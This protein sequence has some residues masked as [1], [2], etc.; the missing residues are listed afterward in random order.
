MRY[1]QDRDIL[2]FTTN[3]GGGE[4]L[5]AAKCLNPRLL[6]RANNWVNFAE[7]AQNLESITSSSNIQG[8]A[9]DS[10]GAFYIAYRFLNGANY[11]IRIV[12]HS[13]KAGTAWSSAVTVNSTASAGIKESAII[14]MDENEYLHIIWTQRDT[15]VLWYARS[16]NPRSIDSWTTQIQI[17]SA[18][19]SDYGLFPRKGRILVAYRDSVSGD[20]KFNYST[21]RGASWAY[22]TAGSAALVTVDTNHIGTVRASAL[23]EVF[24][25]YNDTGED[26]RLTTFQSTNVRRLNELLQAQTGAIA[27]FSTNV[28]ETDQSYESAPWC[29]RNV[30]ATPDTL[31][32]SFIPQKVG[33]WQ[34]PVAPRV[35]SRKNGRLNGRI[36]ERATFRD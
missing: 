13:G 27:S 34:R 32:M 19:E 14:E 11:E 21:N 25:V 1:Y 4:G 31:E 23:G 2:Y 29:W 28:E 22:G 10:T 7:T 15:Q 24:V 26:Y 12:K 35:N 36:M 5:K 18:E 9:S 6:G 16:V 33:V 3:V 20:V 17:G 8:I 30:D